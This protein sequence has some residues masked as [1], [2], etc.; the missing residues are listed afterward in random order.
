MAAGDGH[1]LEQT[2]PP[3]ITYR[4]VMRVV[5]HEP[6]NHGF[7][8]RHGFF[9]RGGNDHSFLGLDHATHLDAL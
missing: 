2:V 3:R 1:I 8:K 4:A 9:V 6:L 5:Q 7:A